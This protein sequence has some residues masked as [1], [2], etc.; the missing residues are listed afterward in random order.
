MNVESSEVGR[1]LVDIVKSIDMSFEHISK[2]SDDDTIDK[3]DL[4][5][6][7]YNVVEKE[8][9]EDT[10]NIDMIF[11]LDDNSDVTSYRNSILRERYGYI[12]Q[13]HRREMYNR[14]DKG[15]ERYIEEKND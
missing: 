4:M 11:D 6:G 9:Y 1:C 3:D 8:G 15:S 10:K 14:W 5:E 13:S 2:I 12:P 7:V